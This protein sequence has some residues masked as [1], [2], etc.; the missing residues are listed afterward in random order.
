M[1]DKKK[2]ISK[3][4]ELFRSIRIKIDEIKSEEFFSTQDSHSKINIIKDYLS[5]ALSKDN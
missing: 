4:L 1:L 3:K 5:S 2:E